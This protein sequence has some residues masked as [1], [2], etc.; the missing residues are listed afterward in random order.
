MCYIIPQRVTRH[1]KFVITCLHF[2]LGI[3]MNY[4]TASWIL[5]AHKS[6]YDKTILLM[7]CQRNAGRLV[8]SKEKA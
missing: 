4:K 7:T 8:R 6:N 1:Q 3:E 2:Y 5:T